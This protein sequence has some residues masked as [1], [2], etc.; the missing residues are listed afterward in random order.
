MLMDTIIIHDNFFYKSFIT[1]CKKNVKANISFILWWIRNL[2][3]ELVTLKN[4]TNEKF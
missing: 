1:K 3:E 2:F 4:E